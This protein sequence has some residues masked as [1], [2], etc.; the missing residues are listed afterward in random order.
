MEDETFDRKEAEA[1]ATTESGKE[2]IRDCAKS[3]GASHLSSGEKPELANA[4]AENT[5]KAYTGETG[6]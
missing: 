4:M 1:W 5:A 2:F 3:W 6:E